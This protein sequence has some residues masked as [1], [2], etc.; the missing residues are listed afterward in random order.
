MGGCVDESGFYELVYP[1]TPR[2]LTKE[3]TNN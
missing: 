1:L 3:F 2:S